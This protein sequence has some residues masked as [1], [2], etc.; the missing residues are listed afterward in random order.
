MSHLSVPAGAFGFTPA[1]A[2]A[3]VAAYGAPQPGAAVDLRLDANEGVAPPAALLDRLREIGP[4]VLRRYPDAHALEALLATR[5]SVSAE[6]VI[7][8]AGADEALDRFCRATLAPGRRIVLPAPTFAMLPRYV[9]LAGGEPLV[10][11]WHGGPYPAEEVAARATRKEAAVIAVVSPNNP[12]GAIATAADLGRLARAAPRALLLCDFAYEE[13]ADAPLTETALA[14]PN[15]VVFRTLSKAYGLA[16]LRV[17]YAAGPAEVIAAMRAAG[18]PY[19]VA[20]PSIAL[21]AARLES[22]AG[23]V[24]RAVAAVKRQREDLFHLLRSLGAES[25][26]SQ[27]N[28]VLA[29]FPDAAGVH[30]A[31]AERGI[32][33]R[34]FPG[35][36]DLDGCLRITC[37]GDGAAFPRLESALRAALSPAARPPSA[38]R[39]TP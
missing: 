3:G 14:L 10:I 28:F 27:A 34:I 25:W 18:S 7:V 4:D 35:E 12:T 20:R 32:A 26:P 17:G 33:V 8:T 39:K 38:K 19:P 23:D 16:G 15:A 24:W 5:L 6:Q 37:P 1:P 13:F 2:L 31:L 21:A 30:Q 9:A 36:A 11:P 29:R 22:R